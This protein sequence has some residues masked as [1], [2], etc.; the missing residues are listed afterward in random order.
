MLSISFYED[1]GHACTLDTVLLGS[2]HGLKIAFMRQPSTRTSKIAAQCLHFLYACMVLCPTAGSVTTSRAS[3]PAV[4][5]LLQLYNKCLRSTIVVAVSARRSRPAAVVG[6]P[7]RARQPRSMR[8]LW[9]IHG[10]MRYGT[11]RLSSYV[12]SYSYPVP[13]TLS[14]WRCSCIPKSAKEAVGCDACGRQSC[15]CT[16]H[17]ADTAP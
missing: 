13:F 14:R 17:M 9:N 11:S 3:Q 7:L 6:L 15:S 4:S 1:S 16:T 8:G 10:T 5:I 2:S 12:P